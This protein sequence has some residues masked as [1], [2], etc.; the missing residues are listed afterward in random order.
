M[1]RRWVSRDP[2]KNAEMKQ[3]P[4]LYEYVRNRPINRVDTLGL[5]GEGSGV[6]ITSGGNGLLGPDD[7]G[8]GSCKCPKKWVPNWQAWGYS[9]SGA[10]VD[11]MMGSTP[12][13]SLSIRQQ[14]P[15]VVVGIAYPPA[16]LGTALGWMAQYAMAE[17]YCNGQTC[18]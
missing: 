11:S 6:P 10:C 4:N 5:Y 7:S 2:L 3:G 17:T 16:G 9:D 14:V 15:I 12:P 1:T 8:G 13:Q 18:Q